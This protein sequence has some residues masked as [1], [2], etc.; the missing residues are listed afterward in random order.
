MKIQGTRA[1][2]PVGPAG[3]YIQAPGRTGTVDSISV[4]AAGTRGAGGRNAVQ[5]AVS[6]MGDPNVAITGHLDI[7]IK[8][9]SLQAV[10]T[11]DGSTRAGELPPPAVVVTKRND[12]TFYA[13]HYSD[14]ITGAEVWV[15]PTDTTQPNLVFELPETPPAPQQDPQPEGTRGFVT[16]AMRGLVTVL[17]WVTDPVVGAAAFSVAEAWENRRRPYGLFQVKNS[18]EFIPPDWSTFSDQPTLLLVHG[19]FSTPQAGFEGWTKTAA[20]ADIHKRYAG[21]CL[22]LAHP[23]MHADP[24]ENVA[25]LSDQLP[26]DKKWTFDT[27]SHSRGGL[28]VRELAA[29]AN[30]DSSCRINKMVM[31][32][33]PN[34]GTP[35]ADADHWTVFLN[36]HTS[37]L[38]L[39]PDTVTTIISE[40]LLCLVK[41]LGSGV[42]RNLPGLA[43][44]NL[45][46]T[47]LP[48]L[49]PR[50][51]S[52]PTGLYVIAANYSVEK[53]AQL[54]EM[55]AKAGDTA[56]TSFFGE[57]NDLV[58][59]TKGC[60]Q[61]E[62]KSAGFPISAKQLVQL[63]GAVHHCNLFEQPKVHE[64]LA[65][66]LVQ[67]AHASATSS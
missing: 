48:K 37:L 7:D 58:V 8:P 66:W 35:L 18:G 20:F 26:K 47:Y 36:A 61:G 2:E 24:A 52:N 38:T 53:A 28:V 5:K 51:Y 50:A 21:R 29:R 41:I 4:Q 59:P 43:A 25:W 17:A 10:A 54:R 31:V 6:A 13:V 22:A 45:N 23:T 14:E 49:A 44:M 56:L 32:A 3:L 62:L 55:L 57:P 15:L 60:S 40:G 12:A 63:D 1:P 11:T 19:T 39:A 9:A 16:A 34:F 30:E 27:V 46:A 64:T 67:D 33:P 42:A 65:H